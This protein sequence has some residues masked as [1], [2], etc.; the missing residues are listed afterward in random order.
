MGVGSGV[1]FGGGYWLDMVGGGWFCGTCDGYG[2]ML[3]TLGGRPGAVTGTL[4][5]GGRYI[6]ACGGTVD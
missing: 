5:G 4:G 6:G 2:G 1:G 3:G